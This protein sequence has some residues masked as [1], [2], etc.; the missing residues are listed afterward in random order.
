MFHDKLN[1]SYENFMFQSPK[2]RKI[3]LPLN[4]IQSYI[5]RSLGSVYADDIIITSL[6]T[7]H[8]FVLL[9]SQEDKDLKCF[10]FFLIEE[11]Q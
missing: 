9:N 1:H 4:Y 6:I 2:Y 3:A 7:I 8:I 11:N 5:A 10:L